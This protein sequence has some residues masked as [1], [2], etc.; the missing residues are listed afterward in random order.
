MSW[1]TL[2]LGQQTFGHSELVV[3]YDHES[4]RVFV[5]FQSST[6]YKLNFYSW[7]QNFPQLRNS[8]AGHHLKQWKGLPY[9]WHYQT[10]LVHK[11]P[12]RVKSIMFRVSS[13]ILFFWFSSKNA[14][15]YTSL[16]YSKRIYFKNWCLKSFL[17]CKSIKLD[18]SLNPQ[19][20]DIGFIYGMLVELH[21]CTSISRFII[22]A[23]LWPAV[24]S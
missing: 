4:F 18:C 16:W 7:L 9:S 10:Q 8:L 14:D 11:Q 21:G 3:L 24:I 2:T 6:S 12:S 15:F 1:V 20:N 22:N 17:T 13:L 23:P 19:V 5:I